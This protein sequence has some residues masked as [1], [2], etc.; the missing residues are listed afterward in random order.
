MDNSAA[1]I[2]GAKPQDSQRGPG[3]RAESLWAVS[4][5][6]LRRNK[7]ALIGMYTIVLF[8]LIALFAPLISPHHPNQ[9]ILE[10]AIKPMMFRGAILLRVNPANPDEPLALPIAGYKVQGDS[11][12]YFSGGASEPEESVVAAAELAGDGPDDWYKEPLFIF[13]TDRFGRDIFS[14]I[15]A[16]A[17]ISISVGI[18]SQFIAL[19]IGM[20]LGALAGYFRGRTDDVILW[21]IN[22]VWSF[23]FILLVI[24]FSVILGEGW[25]QTFTAIGLVA[26]VEIARIVR[27]QIFSL[28]ETEFVGAARALGFS[29]ARI[30]LRHIL[31]NTIGPVMVLVTAGFA[32]AIIAEAGLS[33]LGLGVQPPDASWGQ[34]INDGRGYI[35]AGVGWELIVFPSLAIATAVFAF[36]VFGDGLRDALD[37]R[38]IEK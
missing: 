36:N 18:F 22:V 5:R 11:V 26:W 13:G 33:F 10:Y 24:V 37:P 20:L 32:N 3:R 25:W 7:P 38:L 2:E 4:W 27:G 9:Q 35:S 12:H 6:K 15:L 29:D 17:R 14:R 16:G 31:P 8:V 21:L 30:I 23:P 1:D 28:R 19:T 34:M